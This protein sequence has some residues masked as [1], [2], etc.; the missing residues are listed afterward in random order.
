MQ[1]VQLQVQKTKKATTNEAHLQINQ[2]KERF[3][4]VE[5]NCLKERK[6]FLNGNCDLN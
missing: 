3:G 6:M 2:D 4:I 5:W 1:V